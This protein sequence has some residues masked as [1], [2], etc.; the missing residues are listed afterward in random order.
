MYPSDDKSDDNNETQ[1]VKSSLVV[2]QMINTANQQMANRD[3]KGTKPKG[4]RKSNNNQR[5]SSHDFSTMTLA[6]LDF[7]DPPVFMG[8]MLCVHLKRFGG[9]RGCV[10]SQD[11]PPGKLILVEKQCLNSQRFKQRC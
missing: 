11:L 4:G 10:A 8:D 9:G 6:D 7:V 5:Q 3:D 1:N 2:Q